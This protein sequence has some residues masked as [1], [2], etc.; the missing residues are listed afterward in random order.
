MTRGRRKNNAEAMV[1]VIEG[2]LGRLG[3]ARLYLELALKQVRFVLQHDHT[4]LLLQPIEDM[5]QAYRLI[6]G[7]QAS[8]RRQ[9]DEEMSHE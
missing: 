6:C 5:T 1:E 8:L 7:V 3:N 9:L 4:D 2:D